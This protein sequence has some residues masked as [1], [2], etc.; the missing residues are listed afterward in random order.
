MISTF[1]FL[2]KQYWSFFLLC[3]IGTA[4]G[5]YYGG[6]W[7]FLPFMFLLLFFYE[8]NIAPRKERTW[9]FIESLPLSF[10]KRFIIRVIL[11][12]SISIIIIFLLTFFKKNKELD[13]LIS[14]SDAV[15]I[16]SLFVLSS[17]L[18]RSLSG[19]FAWII[20]T[21]FLSY[22][23]SN[24][25]LYEFVVFILSLFLS[26]YSLSEKRAS[27]IKTLVVPVFISM[28]LLVSGN[29]LRVKIYELCL[30]VPY[31]NLQITVAKSLLKERA[32][33]GKDISVELLWNRNDSMTEPLKVVIPSHYNDKLLEKMENV[34]LKENYCTQICHV[35]GD[36]V[37]NYSKNWNQE[38]LEKYLNSERVTEQIYALRVLEGSSQIMYLP[39]ILQLVKSPEDEVSAMAIE[40]LRKWGDIDLYQFPSNPIF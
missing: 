8:W 7:S 25:F 34:I 35:L 38:R 9:S 37:S 22:L 11:P 23:M 27:K 3:V 10:N 2:F 21:Y 33:I 39:R 24:Y 28:I 16:S 12:L 15:R 36:L 30:S 40:V 31:Y 14:I 29:L 19:F 1:M 26:Y 17:I 4:F 13:F 32:F 5:I 20:F 18:A 6:I